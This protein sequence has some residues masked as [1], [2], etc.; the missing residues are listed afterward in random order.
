[1]TKQGFREWIEVWFF[2]KPLS[3]FCGLEIGRCQAD[4]Q[5]VP[6]NASQAMLQKHAGHRIVSPVTL[7]LK[8]KVLL[9]LMNL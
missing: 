4:G 3:V 1:M 9:W 7:T 5:I 8:E 6:S 2:P